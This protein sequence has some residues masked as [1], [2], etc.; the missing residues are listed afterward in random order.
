MYLLKYILIRLRECMVG[1]ISIIFKLIDIRI[2]TYEKLK[3]LQLA[4]IAVFSQIGLYVSMYIADAFILFAVA[5]FVAICISSFVLFYELDESRFKNFLELKYLSMAIAVIFL[6]TTVN[7][8]KNEEK[9]ETAKISN[10]KCEK[11]LH[12][13]PNKKSREA[14]KCIFELETG[15]SKIEVEKILEYADYQIKDYGFELFL[16]R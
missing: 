3:P 7:I 11:I 13:I 15:N 5:T 1:F 8:S 12:Q 4:S 2:T 9:Y 6:V 14:Y 10:I 16:D